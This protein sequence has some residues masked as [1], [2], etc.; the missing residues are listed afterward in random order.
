MLHNHL[1]FPEGITGPELVDRGQQQATQSGA[2]WVKTDVTA[3]E[4]RDEGLALTTADGQTF[5][6]RDVLLTVGS[7]LALAREAGLE[8]RAGGEPRVAEVITVDRAGRASL[9]GVWAAG[10]AVGM[11]VHTIITAGDG[12][13]V[14][15]NIIS[16]RMGARWVDHDRLPAP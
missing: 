10:T 7:N 3:L 9:P 11:S 5:E 16:L 6:A 8:I 4:R 1:G 14:A 12:A 2:E 13:R 15:I